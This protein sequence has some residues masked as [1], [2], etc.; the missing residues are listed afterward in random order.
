[1]CRVQSIRA[2]N[3]MSYDVSAEDFANMVFD[4][5]DTNGDGKTQELKVE[6]LHSVT[7]CSERFEFNVSVCLFCRWAVLWGVHGGHSEWWNAAED[8]NGVF[9]PHTHS[10]KNWRRDV[11]QHL[12]HT[13]PALWTLKKYVYT[14]LYN[15]ATAE[16]VKT[17]SPRSLSG[18][19]YV[20]QSLGSKY[21][22]AVLFCFFLTYSLVS[23]DFTS[24]LRL[25]LMKGHTV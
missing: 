13:F 6:Y 10:H 21:C 5:I 12:A 8:T 15:C 1:M 23:K 24:I 19:M 25:Y 16:W 22:M 7:I 4:K 14:F 18:Q 11:G 9:G 17:Y 3:G 20:D 2:I